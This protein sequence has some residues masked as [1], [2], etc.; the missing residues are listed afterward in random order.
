MAATVHVHVGQCGNQIGA[1]FWEL[2]RH[3]AGLPPAMAHRSRHTA[4]RGG[5][6]G[7][8][9]GGGGHSGVAIQRAA[10]AA[11]ARRWSYGQAGGRRHPLFDADDGCAR[12]VLVGSEPRVV[13]AA[14]A[15]AGGGLFRAS[16]VLWGAR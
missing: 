8:G 1:A 5:D 15:E 4:A 6:G 16:N 9:G 7:G 13:Q 14:T 3:D 12:A 2:A 10:E 11:A